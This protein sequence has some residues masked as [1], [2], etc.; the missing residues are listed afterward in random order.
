MD[1][2]D[3]WVTYIV[4]YNISQ[5][6]NICDGIWN[7]VCTGDDYHIDENKFLWG[8]IFDNYIDGDISRNSNLFGDTESYGIF[9]NGDKSLLL[10]KLNSISQN[11][12]AGKISGNICQMILNNSNRGDISGN[13]CSNI[14]DNS[15]AFHIITNTIGGVI[16]WNRNNGKIE[17]V[18][19]SA[20]SI[21]IIFNNNNGDIGPGAYAATISDA[22]ANK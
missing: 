21:D 10:T 16:H 22:T 12:V 6:G 18:T 17:S 13:S 20:G 14:L 5:Y 8:A 1:I 9:S 15:N 2:S 3:W 4:D 19:E 11:I 7:N